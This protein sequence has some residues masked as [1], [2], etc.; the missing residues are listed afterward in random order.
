[1]GGMVTGVRVGISKKGS[2]Y[3]IVHFEDFNGDGEIPFFGNSWIQWQN[4]L[5]EGTAVKVSAVV[6]PRR[7]DPDKLD[8]SVKRVEML[9]EETAMNISELELNVN[10]DNLEEIE[11]EELLAL[12]DANPGKTSVII[13]FTKPGKYNNIRVKSLNKKV[14][15]DRQLMEFLKRSTA[16]KSYNLVQGD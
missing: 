11:T 2:Q 15:I 13:S 1:M 4:Y 12:I 7:Y 5:K 16:F 3:G 10:V 9:S 8:I 14:N 6:E